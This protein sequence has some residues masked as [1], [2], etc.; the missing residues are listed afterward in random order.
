MGTL[1]TP[2]LDGWK[3]RHAG[4]RWKGRVQQR[5][6]IDGESVDVIET[7]PGVWEIRPKEVNT[8][9][10]TDD[11]VAD[12]DEVDDTDE[13]SKSGVSKTAMTEKQRRL[14]AV[15]QERRERKRR[16]QQER[17]AARTAAKEVAEADARNGPSGSGNTQASLSANKKKRKRKDFK[18]K[19][20]TRA[21]LLKFEKALRKKLKLIAELKRRVKDDGLIPNAGQTAKMQREKELEEQLATCTRQIASLPED[22]EETASSSSSSSVVSP[23]NNYTHPNGPGCAP[24]LSEDEDG[25]IGWSHL[26]LDRSIKDNLHKLR[27]HKPTAIQQACMPAILHRRRDVIAAAETGSGKT[28]AFGLPLVQM[29]MWRTAA[30]RQAD[31]L[32]ALILTPTRELALQ[33]KAHI[34][35]IAEGTTVTTAAIVGG[36]SEEKQNS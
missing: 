27:F 3:S 2:W 17:K 33:V 9:D 6:E 35:A 11:S 26:G 28:L 15:I 29:I 5:E 36:I 19:D 7:A 23:A 25:G 16:K 32:A 18:L 21:S 34:D 13:G 12:H 8:A 31:P 14:Q 4:F 30:K 20:V 24:S 10:A 22:E 1:L